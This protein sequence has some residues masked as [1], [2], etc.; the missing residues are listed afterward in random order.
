MHHRSYIFLT[1]VDIKIFIFTYR[2][3]NRNSQVII[4]NVVKIL[5]NLS[6]ESSNSSTVIFLFNK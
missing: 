2:I 3:L 4:V 1:V 6:D 5:S